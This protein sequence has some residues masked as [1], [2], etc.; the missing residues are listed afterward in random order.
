MKRIVMCMCCSHETSQ[1]GV[2]RTNAVMR[3]FVGELSLE[4]TCL[5]SVSERETCQKVQV[6]CRNVL[7]VE[8][9]FYFFPIISES[10]IPE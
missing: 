1:L 5:F 4:D 3:S 10:F 7:N 6:G 2:P 9:G 8:L